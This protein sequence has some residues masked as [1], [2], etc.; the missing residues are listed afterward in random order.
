M[1]FLIEKYAG[2][3]PLW[4]APVQVKVLSVSEEQAAYAKEVAAELKAAGI[5]T[6]L[7]ISKESLGKKIREAKLEKVPCTLVLGAKEAEAKTV[8]V[9]NNR[10]GD[11][12][13]VPLADFIKPTLDRIKERANI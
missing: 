13:T 5:R 12:A 1:A 2:A 4:L 6:E 11:K 3:F 7:D 10:N 9:E 8:T